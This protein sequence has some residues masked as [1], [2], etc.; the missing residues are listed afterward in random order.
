MLQ[1]RNVAMLYG[2]DAMIYCCNVTL[3]QYCNGAECNVAQCV[4]LI[5]QILLDSDGVAPCVSLDDMFFDGK[6]KPDTASHP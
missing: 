5:G 4:M 6:N 1:C 2:N 3:L